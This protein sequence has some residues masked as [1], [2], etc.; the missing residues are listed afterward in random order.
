MMLIVGLGNPGPEYAKT[1]HNVGFMV[2]ERLAAQTGAAGTGPV[3]WHL[4]CR[5]LVAE[6]FFQG[7]KVILARPQTYMNNSGEAVAPLLRW[8]GLAP[9][10]L[11]VICDDLD[12]LPGQIRIRKKGGDGGHRGLK[13]VI[14]ALGTNEFAR[15]RIGIGRPEEPAGDVIRWVLGCFN[16]QEA[17][18]I[19][20]ALARAVRAVWV[21]LSE[22]IEK[23]MNQ[24][25]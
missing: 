20:E 4:R 7:Q 21:I 2:V 10:D 8:Y 11:L 23:A 1:R 14:A 13:S 12:L 5:A 24:F 16:P 9:A 6:A 25:N 18:V 17:P 19:E 3:R 15:L 22:G